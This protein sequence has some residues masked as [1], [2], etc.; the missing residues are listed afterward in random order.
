MRTHMN[1]CFGYGANMPS[2][3]PDFAL[4]AKMDHEWRQ[5]AD[6][7]VL[8]DFY[9]LADYS[10]A[11]DV[12]MAWQFDRPE[13][14]RGAVQVFRRGDSKQD[15]GNLVLHGLDPAA[16]YEVLNLDGGKITAEG[17]ALMTQGLAVELRGAPDSAIFTYQRVP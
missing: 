4:L 14:G 10:L 16:R 8:G 5:I 13:I 6:L 17:K 9:P 11:N 12:W 1:A 3:K 2:Q 15:R 7:F